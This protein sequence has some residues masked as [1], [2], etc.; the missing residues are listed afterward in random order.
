MNSETNGLNDF[1]EHDELN[2]LNKLKKPEE[3]DEMAE[4]PQR[5]AL[6][7]ENESDLRDEFIGLSEQ[8]EPAELPGTS[9]AQ[10]LDNPESVRQN[11]S[12]R[13]PLAAG[14]LKLNFFN[15]KKFRGRYLL[16]NDL[17]YSLMLSPS[18]F[19]K[20][21]DVSSIDP[22]GD[23]AQKLIET[24]MAFQGSAMEFITDHYHE[25]RDYK[26][27]LNQAPSLHIFVVTTACNM[28]CV[29]CQ[30]NSGQNRPTHVMDI[31][32][33]RKAVDFALQ[34][35]N[36]SLT[37]EFQG[38]EP[39][40]NFE[41]IRFITEYALANKK[42][43]E[44]TFSIVSNLLL[45]SDEMI[46]FF[47]KYHFG[48]STSVDG[49]DAVHNINRFLPDGSGTLDLLTG[50]LTRL[51]KAG[52][53]PGA[54]QTTTRHSLDYPE[55]IVRAYRDL[56]FERIFIRPLTPLG[57]ADKNWQKIGYSP[58]QFLNFYEKALNEIIR[59]NESGHLMVED[60]AAILLKKI[61]RVPMNYMEL[62]SPCGAG[63]GQ[64][65]YYP[66]GN[67]FTCDEGRMVY[68]SGSDI[69][70]VGHVNDPSFAKTIQNSICKT[71][72]IASTLESLPSCTDCVYQPYCGTC[73][74]INYAETKDLI[75]KEPGGYKCRIYKGLLDL[76]FEK[77]EDEETKKLFEY[78]S[79]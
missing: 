55:E 7:L 6:N 62:R 49:P 57:K 77:M 78:W 12:E 76:I 10:V 11:P 33:A 27:H 15:F 47:K 71:M 37:F 56:G 52:I 40:L 63:I 19:E 53:F 72:C 8:S 45:L 9:S 32:T 24:K 2:R 79:F 68:E 65:A 36:P 5:E 75:E 38:G 25:L 21:R 20:L 48:V 69:F 13:N 44:I 41:V 73:P 59:L 29:Y 22:E 16:T 28:R 39:L 14:R 66:D 46:E 51:R 70:K 30:A 4:L 34:S 31:Q 26:D 18:E 60:H 54:I 1:N 64:L 17:G 42:D 23:L 61:N 50:Q 67:I 35:P 58:D 3:P 43:K 74:V